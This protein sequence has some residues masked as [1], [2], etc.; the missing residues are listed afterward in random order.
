MAREGARLGWDELGTGGVRLL[1]EKWGR[2]TAL[3]SRDKLKASDTAAERAE[4]TGGKAAGHTGNLVAGPWQWG[5]RSLG[6]P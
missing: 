2:V 5:Y 1:L 6:L 3:F 4:R